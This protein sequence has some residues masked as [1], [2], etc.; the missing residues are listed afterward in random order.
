MGN[1]V[2]NYFNSV[3]K[4]YHEKSHSGVWML[5]RSA[6]LNAFR[7]LNFNFNQDSIILDL[8]CGAGYYSK[9]LIEN[10]QSQIYSYDFSGEMLKQLQ[11]KN[12]NTFEVNLEM[13]TED[14]VPFFEYALAMGSLEFVNNLEN[15]MHVLRL[16]AKKS[17][18]VIIL[19][20]Q[21]GIIGFLYRV[22]HKTWGCPSIKRSSTDYENIFAEHSFRLLK[23]ENVGIVSQL[24][25]FEKVISE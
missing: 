15:L 5:A 23:K 2:K 20:P 17:S 19:V 18:H 24:L 9:Y 16:K 8:G 14:Q 7:S 1:K 25:V 22:V 4:Y 10:H 6:E 11:G 3:A 13:I 21:D 12:I